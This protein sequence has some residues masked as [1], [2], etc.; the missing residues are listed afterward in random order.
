M[1]EGISTEYFSFDPT[2]RQC[3]LLA[4]SSPY[5]LSNNFSIRDNISLMERTMHSG[6]RIDKYGLLM[7]G[8]E[9]FGVTKFISP[10]YI[11]NCRLLI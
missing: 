4:D 6:L 2:V 3:D 11:N 9:L 7:S 1:N 10:L 8:F 5:F